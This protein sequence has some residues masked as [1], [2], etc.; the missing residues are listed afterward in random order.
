MQIRF[1]SKEG[2]QGNTF[3]FHDQ[4]EILLIMSEGGSFYIRNHTY[5]MTRGSLFVLT[6]DDLHRSIPQPGSLYQFYSI[7]FYEEE[8]SGFSTEDFDVLSC[9][10][11]QEKVSRRIPLYGDQLDHLLKLIN[12]MEYYLS[13][14]CTSYGKSVLLKSLMAETLVYINFLH[15]VPPGPV[16]P[17]NEELTRLQPVLTY[18]QEH[19]DGDLSLEVLS[20][21]IYVSRYHLSHSFRKIM[22]ITLSDYIIRCRLAHARLLLR[23]GS[24]VQLAGEKSGFNSSAHFIRTF[25]KAMGVSPRQYAKQYLTLEL[26][27]SPSPEHR[28]A[29]QIIP[30]DS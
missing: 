20:R 4:L 24:S 6:P 12:K 14:D 21:Q 17:D 2:W 23:Q 16:P 9:F 29:F 10:R 3:H 8:V 11:Q 15:R 28:D 22:G 27:D 26:Y 30:E 5:P 1:F 25:T 19:I 7:R 18:I 13:V